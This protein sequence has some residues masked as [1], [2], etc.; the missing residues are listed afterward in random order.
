MRSESPSPIS[1]CVW[2]RRRRDD[3]LSFRV[4]VLLAIGATTAHVDQRPLSRLRDPPP[5]SPASAIYAI[6]TVRNR[7]WVNTKVDSA[8][9]ESGR[10]RPAGIFAFTFE[11]AARGDGEIARNSRR[12]DDLFV[13]ARSKDRAVELERDPFLCAV[14]YASSVSLT[15]TTQTSLC[16]EVTSRRTGCFV[17]YSRRI[18]ENPAIFS[19]P[20]SFSFPPRCAIYGSPC[21]ARSARDTDISLPGKTEHFDEVRIASSI[22]LR[23]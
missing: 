6:C 10:E 16:V 13:L 15:L 14:I 12:D 2:E 9:G 21:R 5:P 8:A 18:R 3:A 19:R 23:I 1:V 7:A 20:R 22:S 4:A 11:A 17:I